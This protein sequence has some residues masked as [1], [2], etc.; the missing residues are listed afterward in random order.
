LASHIPAEDWNAKKPTPPV[1]RHNCLSIAGYRNF[2][3]RSS[4]QNTL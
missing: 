1:R 2:L 4:A 3:D